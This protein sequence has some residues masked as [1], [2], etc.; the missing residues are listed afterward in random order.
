MVEV[1]I[2]SDF[3]AQENEI[4]Y[5]FHFSPIYLPDVIGLDA[6]IFIFWMLSFKSAFLLSAFTFLKR[7]FSSSSLSAII[8]KS[9]TY[10][11]LFI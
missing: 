11:R 10:L 7:L 5:Y 4:Y 1:T 8:V 3:G 6:M 2:Y 9:P